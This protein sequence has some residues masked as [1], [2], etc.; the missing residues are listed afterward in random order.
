MKKIISVIDTNIVIS[1]LWGGKPG[2]VI[3]LWNK[4]VFIAAISP[5]VLQEYLAVLS[6]FDITQEELDDFTLLFLNENRSKF[7]IPSEKIYIIKEDHSDNRFLECASVSNADYIVSGDAHLLRAEK[8]GKTQIVN[9]EKFL[10][11][12][13]IK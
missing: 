11:Q 10:K 8:Y 5:D 1:S 9:V 13:L 12:L 7:V 6:R 2:K 3:E 4:G